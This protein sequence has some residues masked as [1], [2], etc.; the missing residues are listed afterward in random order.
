MAKYIYCIMIIITLLEQFMYN[1]QELSRDVTCV[2]RCVSNSIY[3]V[4]Q[5]NIIVLSFFLCVCWYI[6]VEGI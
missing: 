1:V 3:R 5:L 6:N 4:L 2:D